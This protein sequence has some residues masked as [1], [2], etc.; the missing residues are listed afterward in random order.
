MS[1]WASPGDSLVLGGDL[2]L[3]QQDDGGE[4][5]PLSPLG[6]GLLPAPE[7]LN[8]CRMGCMTHFG[9]QD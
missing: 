8:C 3:P 6:M 9:V 2:L 4:P 1:L 7:T 5:A